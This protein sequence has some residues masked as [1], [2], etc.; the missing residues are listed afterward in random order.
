MTLGLLVVETAVSHMRVPI[1]FFSLFPLPSSLSTRSQ[2]TPCVAGV[3]SK[4][5]WFERKRAIAKM[6]VDQREALED[7]R[8]VV[9][10]MAHEYANPL[11]YTKSDNGSGR[12]D[13][14]VAGGEEGALDGA[15]EAAAAS[16]A[17]AANEFVID[18]LL[19]VEA[20]TI[21]PEVRF[22]ALPRGTAAIP[23]KKPGGGAWRGVDGLRVVENALPE[24][25]VKRGWLHKHT[26]QLPG[27]LVYLASVDVSAG[28]ED[29]ADTEDEIVD[30]LRGVVA[31]AAARDVKVRRV[32][33]VSVLSFG[34]GVVGS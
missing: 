26:R 1:R 18:A 33:V 9:G 15:P 13:E 32:V 19:A 4:V 6:Q 11:L 20:E 31:A 28:A 27:S 30:D 8:P 12:R 23:G 22:L 17:A 24:G 7:P 10:I 5:R 14:D 2:T 21:G 3:Q 34:G 29:W 16:A 25:L